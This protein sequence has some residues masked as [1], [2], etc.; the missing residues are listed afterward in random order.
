MVG[1]KSPTFLIMEFLKEYL[2]SCGIVLFA[3]VGVAV[4]IKIVFLI[5]MCSLLVQ[6]IIF[7]IIVFLVVGFLVWMLLFC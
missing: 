5:S 1:C 2:F 6:Q 4:F 3:I 7:S